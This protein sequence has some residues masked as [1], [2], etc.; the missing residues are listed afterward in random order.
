MLSDVQNR[1][2]PIAART[3]SSG[4]TTSDRLGAIIGGRVVVLFPLLVIAFIVLQRRRRKQRDFRMQAHDNP[5]YTTHEE[6]PTIASAVGS[7]E[8][9]LPSG[10]GSPK[11][12]NPFVKKRRTS[13]IALQATALGAVSFVE[14]DAA[15]GQKYPRTISEEFE[16]ALLATDNGYDG[17]HWRCE[18]SREEDQCDGRRRSNRR[19]RRRRCVPVLL[20]FDVNIHF[21]DLSFGIFFL[22]REYFANGES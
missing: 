12:K 6:V 8:T 1:I 2:D 15:Y 9:A 20:L 3:P 4:P 17:S 19:R 21:Q 22:H 5:T 10:Y 16:N 14:S 13:A 18:F 7:V 11:K